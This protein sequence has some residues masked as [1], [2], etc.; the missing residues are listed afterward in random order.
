M[1]DLDRWVILCPDHY[2]NVLWVPLSKLA[3][4]LF[5]GSR[6][7][8]PIVILLLLHLKLSRETTQEPVQ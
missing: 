7:E 4:V 2:D 3:S 8:V 1:V 5:L 6:P